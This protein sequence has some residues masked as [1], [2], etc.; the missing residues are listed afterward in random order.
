MNP[1]KYAL[2]IV[3]LAASAAFSQEPA[4]PLRVAVV[5]V[6]R[7]MDGYEKSKKFEK[8]LEEQFNKEKQKLKDLQDEREEIRKQSRTAGDAKKEELALK[9]QELEY[10]FKLTED[11]VQKTLAI[12]HRRYT[13]EVYGEIRDEVA[14]YGKE[15]NYDIILKKSS[16]DDKDNDQQMQIEMMSNMVL[17]NKEAMDVTAE[18]LDR[19]N[20]RFGK[21]AGKDDAAKTEA[22]VEKK[23]VPAEKKP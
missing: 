22:P 2:P 19:L 9:I 5:D 18:V 16:F 20:T 1:I 10:K 14:L 15:K 7:V 17:F 3:M 12:H 23:T 21:S 8:M 6:P 11:N 4:K 13:Q